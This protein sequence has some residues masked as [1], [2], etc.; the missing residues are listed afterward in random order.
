MGSL[1]SAIAAVST[2]LRSTLCQISIKSKK[3]EKLGNSAHK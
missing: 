3:T 1:N 2:N